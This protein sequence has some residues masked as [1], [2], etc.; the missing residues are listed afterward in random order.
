MAKSKMAAIQNGKT[1]STAAS[2]MFHLLSETAETKNG[3]IWQDLL[4]DCFEHVAPLEHPT[5][6]GALEQNGKRAE[7]NGTVAIFGKTCSTT[8]SSM[9]HRLSTQPSPKRC[10]LWMEVTLRSFIWSMRS[11]TVREPRL[12]SIGHR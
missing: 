11:L 5:F 3:N 10:E 6:S 7:Q 9:L 12:F 2:S 8:A 4:D 1:C